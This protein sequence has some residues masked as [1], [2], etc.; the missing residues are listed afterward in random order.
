[1]YGDKGSSL[2][3]D[4]MRGY[5]LSYQPRALYTHTGV[6]KSKK[7]LTSSGL[8]LATCN[9]T[10]KQKTRGNAAKHVI[11]IAFVTGPPKPMRCTRGSY[12]K[13]FTTA[14]ILSR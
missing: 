8:L 2:C 12:K 13:S 1:M 7:R 3:S 14:V 9:K 10:R 4:V 11:R 5:T 6:K